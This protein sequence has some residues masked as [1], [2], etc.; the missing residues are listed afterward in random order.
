MLFVPAGVLLAQRGL[1]SVE[2]DRA[3]AAMREY[4]LHYSEHLPDYTCLQVTER[5]HDVIPLVNAYDP[6]LAG[7]DA[8]HIRWSNAI[9]EEVELAG[10]RASYRVL[11]IDGRP[12]T[13]RHDQLLSTI[14]AGEFATIPRYLFESETGTTFRWVRNEKLHGRTVL[15]FGFEVPEARGVTI[16]D[17]ARGGR[18]FHLGFTGLLYSDAETKAVSRLTLH[19]AVPINATALTYNFGDPGLSGLDLALDYKPVNLAGR[20]FVLPDRFEVQWHRR[21]PDDATGLSPRLRAAATQA[22]GPEDSDTHGQFKEYRLAS[23]SIEYSGEQ[24][25]GE[26]H[27]VLTFGDVLGSP[28][29][30]K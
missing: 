7:K 9:D 18:E 15:V 16:H 3:V 2:Q 30:E 17:P 1:S 28:R 14:A 20:E 13:L 19:F 4:A 23:S 12:S 27:S 22:L 24:P 21:R 26:A 25:K 29:P 6:D 5:E 10:G 11:K 8:P